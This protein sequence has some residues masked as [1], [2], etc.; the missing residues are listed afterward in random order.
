MPHK[1]PSFK[2]LRPASELS[3]RIKRRNRRADTL[4]EL[5]LRRELWRLGLRYR[6]NVAL[7]PG[8]PDIVFIRARVAV[9]CDGDFWHGRQWRK[10]KSKL[11]NGANPGYWIAKIASNIQRDKRTTAGLE[12]SGW[13][14]IRLWETDIRKDPSTC[15]LMIKKSVEKREKKL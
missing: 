13:R 9:F 4:H 3:S 10:L 1:T 12:K 6:K 14:V 15:A 11:V 7:L 8:E 5:A 2:N